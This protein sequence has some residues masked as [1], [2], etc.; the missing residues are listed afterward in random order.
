M[1]SGILARAAE[2]A[3]RGE[4]AV[5]ITLVAVEGPAPREPG[6][7]M[8]VFTGGH[9]EGTI[10]GGALELRAVEQAQV[11]LNSG[12]RTHLEVVDLTDRG[13]RCGGGRAT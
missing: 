9:T 8:L 10:G 13:L 11:L 4:T 12:N 5:L 7:R 1:D 2:A 3:S 6:T